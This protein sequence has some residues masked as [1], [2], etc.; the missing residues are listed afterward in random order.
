MSS[1]EEKFEALITRLNQ[2]A[3]KEPTLG[4][5]EYMQPQNA[6]YV[7]NRSYALRPN[8]NLTSH[9]HSELRNH[10]NLSYENQVIVPHE[11]H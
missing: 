9:Y 4:E 5:I 1:L 6:N 2:Q 7:N 11:P 8:N 3:L 10:E